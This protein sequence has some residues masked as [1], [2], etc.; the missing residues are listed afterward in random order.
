VEMLGRS[1]R[2]KMT[3]GLIST[4]H[5]IDMR[6]VEVV[7]LWDVGDDVLEAGG[8][9]R[10]GDE[11]CSSDGEEGERWHCNTCGGGG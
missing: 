9:L 11:Q 1:S 10:G 2:R 7:Y 4:A 3:G 5:G 8:S 6:G